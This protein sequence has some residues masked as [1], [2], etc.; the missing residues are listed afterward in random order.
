MFCCKKGLILGLFVRSIG[1]ILTVQIVKPVIGQ[2]IRVV[3]YI[4][5]RIAAFLSFQFY[6]F[7]VIVGDAQFFRNQSADFPASASELA[8]NGDKDMTSTP[9]GMCFLFSLCFFCRRK[10][11]LYSWS[12]RLAEQLCNEAYA[13]SRKD[14]PSLTPSR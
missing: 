13:E 6:Q 11:T 14:R 3:L 4:F 2:L 8:A 10:Q 7:A 1:I 9:G 12:Q 5:L